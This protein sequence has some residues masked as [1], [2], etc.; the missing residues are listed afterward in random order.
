[1]GAHYFG[2]LAEWFMALASKASGRK[3]AEVRILYPPQPVTSY[4]NIMNLCIFGDSITYGSYDPTNGG[5]VTLLRNYLEKNYDDINTYGL[6]ICGNTTEDLLKRFENEARARETDVVILAIGI[7][8]AQY[9]YSKSENRVSDVDFQNHIKKLFEIAKKITSKIIFVGLTSV[10]ETKTTPIPW[11]TDKVYKNERINLFDK[12]IE[13][14]CTENN[15]LF[16]QT[17]NLLN[18]DE[19]F[20][21]LH[22]NTQGHMKIFEKIKP[23]VSKLVGE[24]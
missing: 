5:W 20:D 24:F 21:G 16:V 23:L 18:K 6:G 9:I 17:S 15:L 11:N 19:L 22:P 10:D 1:M 14:F 12:F 7:N 4:N 8:D 2:G 13:N 3:L